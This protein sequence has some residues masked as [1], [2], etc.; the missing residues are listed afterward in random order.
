MDPTEFRRVSRAVW[1]TM[2]AGWDERHPYLEETA[3]PVTERMLERLAPTPGQTVLDLAA[4]TGV[5][6][7]SAAAFVGSR[8]RVIVSDF[9]EAMVEVAA[10]PAASLGLENVECRV[11]DAERLDLPDSSVDGVLCRWGPARQS[12]T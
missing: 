10:R 8:G 6:G 12:A 9:A 2:A 11:L 5:V 7:F 3:R 4:G 1:T